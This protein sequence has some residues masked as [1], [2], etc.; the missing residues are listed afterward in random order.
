MKKEVGPSDGLGEYGDHGY[1]SLSL[2][3]QD[4]EVL[5]YIC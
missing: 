1:I 5:E 3:F 2:F 4:Y